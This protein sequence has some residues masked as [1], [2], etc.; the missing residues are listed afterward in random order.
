MSSTHQL[1]ARG[2]G[3][4]RLI[5]LKMI[6]E[7]D[8]PYEEKRKLAEY[9][10]GIRKGEKNNDGSICWRQTERTDNDR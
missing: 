4:S 9:L 6:D 5:A 7:S 8:L 3:K 2:S 10:F 1:M